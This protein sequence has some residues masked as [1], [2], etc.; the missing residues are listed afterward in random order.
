MADD[1]NRAAWEVMQQAL[2]EWRDFLENAPAYTD[3][4]IEIS[5]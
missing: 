3:R 1:D 2:N 5:A 4:R